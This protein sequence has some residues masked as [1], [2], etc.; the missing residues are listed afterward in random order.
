MSDAE[1]L[2]LGRLTDAESVAEAW[3]CGVR[4]EHFEQ[5][6]YQAIWNFTTSYWE[7]S[8]R[9]S[10][11]T[12]WV[13]AEEF[14][15]YVPAQSVAEEIFELASLLRRRYVTNQ[16]Q[17]MMRRAAADSVTDPIRALSQLHVEAYTASEKSSPRLTRINMAETAEQRW[18]SYLQS[19]ENAPQLLGVPYGIDLLDAYTGGIHPGELAVVGAFAKTGKTWFLC[20]AAVAALRRGLRPVIFTLEVGLEDIQQRIDAL[21]SG[22]SYNDIVRRRLD[23]TQKAALR[24]TLDELTQTGLAVERPDP[25]DRTVPALIARAR[26]LG[27]DYVIIDQL[28]RLEAGH[29]TFST[30]ELRASVMSQL[31]IEISRA[32][33]QV[34]CLMAVQQRRGEE[35][36]SLE[37]FADAAEIEREVDMALGLYRNG[38]LRRNGQMKCEI[39]GSRRSDATAFMLNWE[40]VQHT[41]ITGR[42]EIVA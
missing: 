11:P 14:S 20:N 23:P 18:E 33:S 40:L 35:D 42:A 1:R 7:Q 24:A 36:P 9:A 6:L 26:Q 39:L 25:G 28:S 37:S 30:K 16:L 27:S 29:K 22:V 41:A 19:H 3:N 15:G 17:E 31:S 21:H 8:Q 32:G 34:P 2:L 13:L 5:P 12:P 4:P 38:E 10:V